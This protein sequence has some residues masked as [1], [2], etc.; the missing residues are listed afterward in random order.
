MSTQPALLH[1]AAA[2]RLLDPQLHL[3]APD[4][5]GPE[6]ANAIWKKVRR[7]EITPA[8]ASQILAALES[9]GL[10]MHPSRGLLAPAFQLA[11]ALGRPVYDNLY[12]ALA[13]PGTAL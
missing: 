5:I 11:H 3:S 13:S 12:L 4:L 9:M 8:E 10:E 6:F 7:E 1:S 2:S